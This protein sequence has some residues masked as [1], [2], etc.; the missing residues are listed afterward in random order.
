M[1]A[2]PASTPAQNTSRLSYSYTHRDKMPNKAPAMYSVRPNV[3][4]SFQRN[5]DP[6]IAAQIDAGKRTEAQRRHSY[7][8]KRQRPAPVL[9]PSPQFARSPDRNAFNAAMSLERLQASKLNKKAA[10]EQSR[11][12]ARAQFI[13]ERQ[14]AAIKSLKRQFQQ[15]RS[16]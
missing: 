4:M 15:A 11:K 5:R 1:N 6:M 2:K 8:V 14:Q 12:S 9:K 16:H 10:R 3:G 13:Q 7:M